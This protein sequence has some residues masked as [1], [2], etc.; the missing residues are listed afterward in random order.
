MS[1]RSSRIESC[2]SSSTILKEPLLIAFVIDPP[3]ALLLTSAE[4]NIAAKIDS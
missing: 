2:I 1:V 4:D 3:P